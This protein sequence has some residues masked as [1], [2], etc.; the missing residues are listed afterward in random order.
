[1]SWILYQD[2]SSSQCQDCISAKQAKA[3]GQGE[4]GEAGAT[5]HLPAEPLQKA[6]G[7]EGR[8]PLLFH[9]MT[10]REVTQPVFLSVFWGNPWSFSPDKQNKCFV[11]GG[12]QGRVSR[13]A[14]A[15]W[16][17]YLEETNAR[18]FGSSREGKINLHKIKKIKS[19]EEGGALKYKKLFLQE[20]AHLGFFRLTCLCTRKTLGGMK[21]GVRNTGFYSELSKMFCSSDK[22][23]KK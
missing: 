11:T 2:L 12:E 8:V 15:S 7:P 20:I 19:G 14:A 21:V 13:I 23:K 10:T 3:S 4:E 6:S 1:M 22:G 16:E 17:K 5:P 9:A 18:R